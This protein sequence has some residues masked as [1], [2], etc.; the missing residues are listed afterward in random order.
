M[1]KLFT[2]L[3]FII[4][5]TTTIHSQFN[6]LSSDVYYIGIAEATTLTDAQLA[7]MNNLSQ[8]IQV[9]FKSDF[10]RTVIET[11][12]GVF[13]STVL[14]ANT[15]SLIMLSDVGEKVEE[16]S[17]SR[18]RVTKFVTK[19]SVKEIFTQRGNQIIS[20]LTKADNELNSNSS[21]LNLAEVFKNY[22][23]AFLLSLI[24]PENPHYVFTFDNHSSTD[25]TNLLADNIRRG[26]SHFAFGLKFHPE[27]KIP[28][29]ALTWK[30]KITYNNKLVTNLDFS[31]FDGVGEM[32]GNVTNGEA[33]LDFYY[34]SLPTDKEKE[35]IINIE[36]FYE[37]ELDQLLSNA[38]NI[39]MTKKLEITAKSFIPTEKKISPPISKN[40]ENKKP[41]TPT[42][43]EDQKSGTVIPTVITQLI[44]NKDDI[45][46]V[47]R[48][49]NQ[50]EKESKLVT[51]KTNDFEN[52]N[53]L[54][55]IVID[56][57]NVNSIMKFN[58]ENC[59]N[60]LDNQVY[61][62]KHFSGKKILW[63]EVVK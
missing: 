51:G 63:I 21:A 25:A 7:A 61:P 36:C 53:G 45:N 20:Y 3:V 10:Q 29:E 39:L 50:F 35:F 58:N 47:F 15:T 2:L 26:L 9:I 30:Y 27:R 19:Q 24:T 42:K 48:L 57:N 38:H 33:I 4:L 46:A 40:I 43:K 22:Y 11:N 41:F 32:L 28:G 12:R 6:T 13:D 5:A 14:F 17:N 1:I 62:L 54:F 56:K 23:K 31:Y 34:K 49:L 59:F 44:Q 52:L 8:Q 37:D 16:I 60:F 55:A 18:F